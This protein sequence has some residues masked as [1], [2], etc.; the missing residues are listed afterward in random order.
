MNPSVH[1]RLRVMREV[2]AV[3]QDDVVA[4]LRQRGVR[5]GQGDLS[6]IECGQRPISAQLARHI[7]DVVIQ[8]IEARLKSVKELAAQ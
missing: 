1:V 2:G 6:Q 5:L 8:I 7:S 3:R 4:G